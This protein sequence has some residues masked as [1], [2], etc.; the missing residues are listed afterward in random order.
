MA[1]AVALRAREVVAA[2]GAAVAAAREVVKAA[3]VALVVMAGRAVAP[4]S[5]SRRKS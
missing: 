4:G 2:A 3:R 1:S 5:S